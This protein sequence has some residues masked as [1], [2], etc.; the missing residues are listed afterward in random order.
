MEVRKKLNIQ[1]YK[2][3]FNI[4]IWIYDDTYFINLS[5]EKLGRWG[6]GGEVVATAHLVK[7]SSIQ[8]LSLK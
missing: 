2:P 3:E 8:E 6:G 7:T 4:F 5:S 1:T